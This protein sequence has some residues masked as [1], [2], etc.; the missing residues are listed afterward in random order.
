MVTRPANAHAGPPLRDVDFFTAPEALQRFSDLTCYEPN[1]RGPSF[2]LDPNTPS[3]IDD[4]TVLPP[5]LSSD[6]KGPGWNCVP[7][8]EKTYRAPRRGDNTNTGRQI[9]DRV[10]IGGARSRICPVESSAA[11]V[12]LQDHRGICRNSVHAPPLKGTLEKMGRTP[13]IPLLR[14]SLQVWYGGRDQ[15]AHAGNCHHQ[16][17]E[18]EA[19]GAQFVIA[20]LCAQHDTVSSQ[21]RGKVSLAGL[22][23]PSF[24]AH[25]I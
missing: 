13:Q 22:F 15:K 6:H 19:T 23:A 16:F 14:Q 4:H 12:D 8:R 3:W 5:H 10:L 18:A 25:S 9:P 20:P 17:G 11:G 21:V 7:A 24:G 2:S 1:S